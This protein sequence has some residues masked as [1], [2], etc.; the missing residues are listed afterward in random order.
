[1]TGDRMSD[2]GCS[3]S[4]TADFAVTLLDVPE[5]RHGAEGTVYVSYDD[6][7]RVAYDVYKRRTAATAD[8][9]GQS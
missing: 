1:M 3:L 9:S 5:H 8:A 2:E 6:A 7:V 4:F